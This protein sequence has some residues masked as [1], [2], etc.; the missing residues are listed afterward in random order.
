MNIDIVT[1]AASVQSKADLK[2]FVEQAGVKGEKGD[3]GLNGDQPQPYAVSTT[4][5]PT[6]HYWLRSSPRLALGQTIIIELDA[7]LISI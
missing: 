7:K 1:L 2:A 6:A 3:Q 5:I 4:T